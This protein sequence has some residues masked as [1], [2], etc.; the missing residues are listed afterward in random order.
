MPGPPHRLRE[1]P[2]GLTTRAV[3][4]AAGRVPGL[5][6]LPVAKLLMLGEVALLAHEHVTRLTPAQRRRLMTLVRIGRGR[7]GRLTGAERDELAE[8]LERLEGRRFVG[9]AVDRLSPL[10]I[11][12]RVLYGRRRS[13]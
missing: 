2:S 1:V 11:P 6:R 3:A 4:T 9:G 12:K 7:T 13:R 8:L 5:K 10:P